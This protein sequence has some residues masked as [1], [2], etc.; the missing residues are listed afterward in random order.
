MLG[1]YLSLAAFCGASAQRATPARPLAFES[2]KGKAAL[3]KRVDQVV[4]Q[5]IRRKT[6]VGTVVLVQRDGRVV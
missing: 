1:V 5:A 6:I 2:A 4:A 3:G